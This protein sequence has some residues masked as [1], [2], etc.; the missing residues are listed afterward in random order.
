MFKSSP[1]ISYQNTVEGTW[2]EF[3]TPTGRVAFVLTKARLGGPGTDH[4][5]RL[6]SHLIPVREALGAEQLDFNQLL[7]RDLDDHRVSEKLLPYLLKPKATGPAFFPPIMTVLL[8][9][10][11]STPR[12]SFPKEDFNGP[13]QADGVQYEERRYGTAYKVQKHINDDGSYH[14]IKL[15]RLEWNT[16]YAKL[17]VLDGQHRAMALLAIDRTVN[18]QWSHSPGNRFRH[19]YER[20]VRELLK[21][22]DSKVDLNQIEVPVTVCWFPDL[23]GP[24][25]SPHQAARKLFVDVNKEART[26]SEARLTLLSDTEL[27]N[28]L[29]RSLLNRLREPNPPLPLFAIEYDNPDRDAARPVKWSVLTNLNLLK[30]AV[31]RCVFGPK[32][33]LTDMRMAFGGRQP[34]S[35]MD[36]FMRSQLNMLTLFEESIKD[37]DRVI[38]RDT[39]GNIH[40]PIQ[41]AESII[42]RFMSSW[43]SAILT[44]LGTLKPYSAHCNALQYT[45]DHWIAD[46]AFSSL[47]KEALFSGVGMYWTLRDSDNHWREIKEQCR[48]ENRPEPTPPDII[49]A[50]GAI[51]QKFSDFN[52]QRTKEY[53]GKKSDKETERTYR[54]FETVN[55]HA[56]QLGAILTLASLAHSSG[57][58]HDAVAS[59]ANTVV[60]AWNA[61]LESTRGGD[62]PRLLVFA[63]EGVIKNPINR[64]GK[65]DTPFAV[66][67]RYFWLEL[68]R[69]QAAR[70]V[71]GSTV[72][73]A[74]VD[75]L[76]SAARSIYIEHLIDEQIKALQVADPRKER[77]KLR[78]K[79]RDN[80]Q[81]DLTRAYTHWFDMSKAQAESLIEGSLNKSANVAKPSQDD[82]AD[83]SSELPGEEAP[84]P[85]TTVPKSVL[86]VLSELPDE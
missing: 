81:R 72:S 60:A 24:G 49:K 42:Q 25:K 34:W 38:A 52:E 82:L 3:R 77:D 59:F 69:L 31:I 86:E 35:E 6:T 64:L 63:K 73:P 44:V 45:Y 18:N 32:K 70:A 66:Y 79:A 15:G 8:P 36:I 75:E 50:W 10:D 54:F 9:F 30:F 4:E 76:A 1:S 14:S 74:V 13:V 7:Q 19:F 5:R 48:R 51:Q 11:G 56:C 78:P 2:G 43:G 84:Q 17:V 37:G 22:T 33:Y 58:T 23:N 80:V 68:L 40:F 46:D 21:Q 67:F 62:E 83:A 85:G 20:Q 61:A 53:L 12:D 27:V 16:E 65:M 26:P 47:A 71:L 39:I 28:I 29:T 41:H 55:T 57:V